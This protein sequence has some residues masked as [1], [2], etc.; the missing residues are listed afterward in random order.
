MPTKAGPKKKR[1]KSEAEQ[2]RDA[3]E[4]HGGRGVVGRKSKVRSYSY[5]KTA[6][7]KPKRKL[8]LDKRAA[9]FNDRNVRQ[10]EPWEEAIL[11]VE[12]TK[13]MDAFARKQ[14]ECEHKPLQVAKPVAQLGED[15]EWRT[16]PHCQAVLRWW[17]SYTATLRAE[18]MS[19][20]V[21]GYGMEEWGSLFTKDKSLWAFLI[22]EAAFL[23]G[24]SN[25]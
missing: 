17:G 5:K 13:V 12:P 23:K 19:Y 11:F 24:E 20:R 22:E 14:M 18:W 9:G 15:Q 8:S 16:C 21:F 3:V 6:K 7:P 25:G 2:I 1:A 10:W 4:E